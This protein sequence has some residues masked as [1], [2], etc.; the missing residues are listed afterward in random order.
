M[1]YG[2]EISYFTLFSKSTQISEFE[3]LGEA[4]IECLE[5]IGEVRAATHTEDGMAFEFW[6]EYEDTVT[7]LYL[8]PYDAAIVGIGV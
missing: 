2:K 4:V 3:T 8:F 1:L 5:D 7:C 6:S